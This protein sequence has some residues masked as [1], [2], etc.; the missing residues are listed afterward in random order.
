MGKQV[1]EIPDGEV[2]D[3]TSGTA[4]AEPDEEASGAAAEW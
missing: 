2:L 3:M 4:L 1:V